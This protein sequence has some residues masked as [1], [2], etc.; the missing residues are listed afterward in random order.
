MSWATDSF[1]QMIDYNASFTGSIAALCSNSIAEVEHNGAPVIGAANWQHIID[2]C[3]ISIVA[4][5]CIVASCMIAAE[6]YG[7]YCKT[8]GQVDLEIVMVMIF[9]IIIPVLLVSNGYA[10]MDW[11]SSDFLKN[12]Y[13]S[14]S[15]GLGAN[16]DWNALKTAFAATTTGNGSFIDQI[17]YGLQIQV[18][19]FINWIMSILVTC[20]LYVRLIEMAIMYLV[21]PIPIATLVHHEQKQIGINFFKMYFALLLQG[22]IIL[23]YFVIYS[24]MIQS[25]VNATSAATAFDIWGFTAYQLVF[26]WAVMTS[27]HLSKRL[28]GT[29]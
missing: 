26:V 15:T 4:V 8:N 6:I 22:L 20:I 29:F 7:T 21:S 27:G 24:Y 25:F 16:I 19:I 10:I 1:N 23:I 9:R 11:F 28:L 18:P 14:V 3:E 5:A 12:I 13:S 2:I 17:W